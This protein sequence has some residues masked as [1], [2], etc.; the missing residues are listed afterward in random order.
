VVCPLCRNPISS[1]YARRYGRPI[2]RR[3]LDVQ[4]KNLLRSLSRQTTSC[5]NDIQTFE[6]D[7]IAQNIR[8]GLQSC[9]TPSLAPVLGIKDV[10]D[11]II[12]EPNHIIPHDGLIDSRIHGL[13][14]DA[15]TIWSQKVKPIVTVYEKL[16]KIVNSHRPQYKAYE[17]AFTTLYHSEL[18]RL[19]TSPEPMEN[20]H[21]IALEHAKTK[22][23]TPKPLG[24]HRCTTE[25]LWVSLELRLTLS[26]L[27]QELINHYLTMSR[28]TGEEAIK[29]ANSQKNLTLAR[30][31]KDFILRGAYRDAD[32]AK[33]LGE[34]EKSIRQT[35]VS[36]VQK[37]RLDFELNSFRSAIELEDI[38]TNRQSAI[39]EFENKLIQEK[40]QVA[41]V[42]QKWTYQLLNSS[43][44]NPA[45]QTLK[46]L[47]ELT[48]DIISKWE[49]AI[50]TFKSGGLF[51]SKE[52]LKSVIGAFEF[53]TTG[54][55]FQCPN[56][57]PFVSDFNPYKTLDILTFDVLCLDNDYRL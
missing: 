14:E 23:G 26:R 35:A 47:K 55:W 38:K 18:A 8:A 37:F 6:I 54:H 24:I 39:K 57:H 50:N 49:Q 10:H 7:S 56:G 36:A 17:A 20:P 29:I 48:N 9:S 21:L 33:R 11:Q 15:S 44:T 3:E 12:N 31:F 43:P 5:R 2:K 41:E 40:L 32:I 19:S 22:V 51:I 34:E 27:A 53:Q 30:L 28:Q 45:H 25:A 1:R 42:L 13:P 52:E 16:V 46:E 4:E